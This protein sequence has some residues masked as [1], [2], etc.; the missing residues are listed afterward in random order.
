MADFFEIDFLDVETKSSGDAIC[1]RY[2]LNGLTCIHV[3]DAGY[4][5]TGEKLVAHIRKHYNNPTYI[6]H[7]VVTHND[8]DHTGGVEQVLKEFN[9]GAIWMLCPWNYA[10][11][12]LHRFKRYS[13]VDGLTQAL[14]DSFPNLAAMEKL[15]I[16]K[17][18]PICE[19]F[20]GA[21]IGAFHVLAPTRARFLD[22]VVA[23]NKTPDEATAAFDAIQ[24]AFL[25]TQVKAV[26]KAANWGDEY[27][28]AGETSTENE[29]SVV[30]YATLCGKKILLTGDTGRAGL[31]EVIDYAP[32]VGLIFPGIDHFQIPHH[33]GRHNV[34]TELLDQILGPRLG[35]PHASTTF[36]AIISSAKE[37]ED[38][39]R[40]SVVRAMHHRGAKVI[41]TEGR[42]VRTHR[43]AP[44]RGWVAVD[45]VSYPNEQED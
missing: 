20:Q 33:G 21:D 16:K 5:T 10:A 35:N 7:L 32:S 13:T 9:I 17:D 2:E 14:K 23:S 40:K 4:Q 39:P 44:D 22:L 24:E 45:G 1:L 8:G 41:T 19:P 11:E 34:N 29:M 43:N 3:V 36:T 30:Q 28:P 6:D 38:H 12:L 37:D 26:M 18:I 27:F 31:Q 25:A 42:D 15:A